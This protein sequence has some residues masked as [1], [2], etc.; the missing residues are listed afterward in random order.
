MTITKN[1]IPSLFDDFVNAC[2]DDATGRDCQLMAVDVIENDDQYEVKA[3]FP[4][5]K[6]E[7][8]SISVLDRDL[9]IEAKQNTESEKNEGIYHL[10]ERFSGQWRRSIRLPE[11]GDPSRIVAKLDNGVLTI[12]I[13]KSEPKPKKAITIE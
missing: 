7:E 9:T 13:P 3:N 11:N 6:R 2:F 5:L 4:G 8:I 12:R 10:K 1:S